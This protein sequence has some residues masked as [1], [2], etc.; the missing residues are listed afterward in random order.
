MREEYDFTNAIK[1]PY[2]KQLKKQITIN[3]NEDV[4]DY[5]KL[6]AVETGIPYQTLINLYLLDCKNNSRKLH[7]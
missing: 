4:L 6:M 1:N 3:I 5:F 2:T 7:F